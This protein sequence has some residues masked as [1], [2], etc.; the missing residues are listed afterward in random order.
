MFLWKGIEYQLKEYGVK[1]NY[2]ITNSE[3]DIY[4]Q[5]LNTRD[6]KNTKSWDLL[7]WGDDDWYYQNPWT[8]FFYI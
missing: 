6:S 7:I 1:L 4:E 8:V 5:L 2:I 3:K